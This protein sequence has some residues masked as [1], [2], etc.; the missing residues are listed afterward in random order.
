MAK[1]P[2]WEGDKVTAALRARL[3][4]NM[5]L[6]VAFVQGEVRKSIN[7]GNPFGINPSA[8]GEPPKKV[9]GRLFQSIATRVD[10]SKTALTGA[11]GSNVSYARRLELGFAG[12]DSKGR[13]YRM[14]PRPYLRPAIIDNAR[15]IRAIL[16]KR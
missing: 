6:A 9:T 4:Q 5:R 3:T 14:K 1:K 16:T 8:P 12:T 15:A 10:M 7:R 2:T 11:V 13:N